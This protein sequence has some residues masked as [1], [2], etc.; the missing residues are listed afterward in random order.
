MWKQYGNDHHQPHLAPS[1]HTDKE[2]HLPNFEEILAYKWM[3]FH[4][5]NPFNSLLV[6]WLVGN[7]GRAV[8]HCV[9]TMKNCCPQNK[10]GTVTIKSLTHWGWMID[11]CLSNVTMI[12]SD[13]S[14][15]PGQRQA[16]TWT[17]TGILLIGHIVTNLSE[18]S[19]EIHSHSRKCIC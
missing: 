2:A 18:I 12:C 11:I 10:L 19:I 6:G 5:T 14:L 16:I 17:N 7:R 1:Y 15:S 4:S 8:I 9:R 13:N 3:T